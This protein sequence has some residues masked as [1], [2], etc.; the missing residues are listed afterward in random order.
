M[1]ASSGPY[2][3]TLLEPGRQDGEQHRGS[4]QALAAVSLAE[5]AAERQSP[6]T[7]LSWEE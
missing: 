3:E 4:R 6:G 2:P 7:A 5:V 1:Q